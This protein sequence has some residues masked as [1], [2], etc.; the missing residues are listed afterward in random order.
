MGALRD[1]G[2]DVNPREAFKALQ[3]MGGKDFEKVGDLDD[4]NSGGFN[5]GDDEGKKGGK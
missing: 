2:I 5:E 3:T 4:Y 1:A